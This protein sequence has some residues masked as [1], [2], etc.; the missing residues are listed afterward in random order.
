[1][2]IILDYGM[3]NSSSEAV[4]YVSGDVRKG[5]IFEMP[6]NCRRAQ[7]KSKEEINSIL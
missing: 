7:G 4:N 1:M 6:R 2:K 5:N 3:G